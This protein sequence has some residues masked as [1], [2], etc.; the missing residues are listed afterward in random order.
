MPEPEN[1][2]KEIALFLKAEHAWDAY[3]QAM[4]NA[5][6]PIENKYFSGS[7]VPGWQA[8]FNMAMIRSQESYLLLLISIANNGYITF[9]KPIDFT[10]NEITEEA[11]EKL[12]NMPD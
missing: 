3:I 2:D 1:R 10:E 7:G 12:N 5:H 6:I 9:P 4:V 11:P 8:E